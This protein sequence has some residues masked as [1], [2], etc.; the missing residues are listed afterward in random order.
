LVR[1]I[2][3]LVAVVAA[4]VIAI[5]LTRSSA[6]GHGAPP[7]PTRALAGPP[8]S[9]ASLRGHPVLIDFFASWC[10]PC[11]AEA[12]TLERVA[13]A[14]GSRARVVAVDW[15]DSERFGRQFVSRYHWTFPVLD[16]PNGTAGYAYGIQGLPVAFVLDPAGRIVRRLVG[17][18]SAAGFMRAVA[19][20]SR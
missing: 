1:T 3:A 7:L 8:T 2:A 14:L 6:S 16:D 12:P 9:L 19:F 20:A 13:R 18:Q 17:P 10:A 4:V 15:S 11:R 5:L